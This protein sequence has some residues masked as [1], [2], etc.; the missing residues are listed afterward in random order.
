MQE[1]NNFNNYDSSGEQLSLFLNLDGFEGP[2]DLLLH[3]SREQKVDLTSISIA[4]LA[5]Q[6]IDFHKPWELNKNDDNSEDV[7]KIASTA[8]NLFRILNLYLEPVIPETSEKIKNYLKSNQSL[9]DLSTNLIDHQ[10]DI[11]KPLMFR[12]EDVEINKLNEISQNG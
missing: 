9:D 1:E 5:N 7:K 2:I 8:I 11:F 3:L 10:I 4:E 12:I 6:Y